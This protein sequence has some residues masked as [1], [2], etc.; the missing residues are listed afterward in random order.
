MHNIQIKDFADIDTLKEVLSNVREHTFNVAL[1]LLNELGPTEAL[2]RLKH[3]AFKN[4]TVPNSL[5]GY[6]ILTKDVKWVK[7]L[8]DFQIGSK[9][10]RILVLEDNPTLAITYSKSLYGLPT[11]YD[12]RKASIFAETSKSNVEAQDAWVIAPVSETKKRG[13]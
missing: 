8:H 9:G 13:K 6:E 7:V 2:V 12:F 1:H 4:I 10:D 3:D 11:I 5:A